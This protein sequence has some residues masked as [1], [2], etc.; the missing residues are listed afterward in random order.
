MTGD[1]PS[2]A[3]LLNDL[4]QTVLKE[5]ERGVPYTYRDVADWCAHAGHGTFSPESVRQLRRGIRDNPTAR[6]ME[7]L[8]AFFGVPA[9]AFVDRDARERVLEQ[10]ARL[11]AERAAGGSAEP[12]TARIAEEQMIARR[13]GMLPESRRALLLEFLDIMSEGEG[14]APE[15]GGGAS[16]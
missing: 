3:D 1:G 8:A 6:H 4:F 14:A 15:E 11:R 2:L 12:I 7:G 13:A 10:L 16:E 5:P 9:S